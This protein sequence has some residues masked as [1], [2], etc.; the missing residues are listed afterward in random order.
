M[1]AA[2]ASF[3]DPK[4]VA[5]TAPRPRQCR[6]P[7]LMDLKNKNKIKNPKIT[8]MLGRTPNRYVM[9]TLWDLILGR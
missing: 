1:A 6:L 2:V 3:Q 5:N 8:Q 4:Q 7:L 9:H